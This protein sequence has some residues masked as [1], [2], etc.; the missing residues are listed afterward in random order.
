MELPYRIQI[1]VKP[2]YGD[3]R[4]AVEEAHALVHL[5]STVIIN[6]VEMWLDKAIVEADDGFV[7]VELHGLRPEGR[8]LFRDPAQYLEGTTEEVVLIPAQ[9]IEF[10]E[11][12]YV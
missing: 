8:E 2:W 11:A 3:K 6:E 5:P 9:W 1:P 10:V 7:T 4:V 12:P